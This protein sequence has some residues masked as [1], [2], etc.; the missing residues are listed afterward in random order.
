[1]G[2]FLARLRRIRGLDAWHIAF[3]NPAIAWSSGEYLIDL[4]NAIFNGFGDYYLKEPG[5]KDI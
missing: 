2:L 4:E 3:A 5:T 1:V